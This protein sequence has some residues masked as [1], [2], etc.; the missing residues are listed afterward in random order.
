MSATNHTTNYE[1][2]I[3]IGTDK[4]AWLVDW[5]GAMN[6]IDTAIKQAETKADQAGTDVGSIQSDII[7]INSSLTTLNNAVSQ[8][9][10]DTNA[11]TGSIN[12][13]Q[14]L[15][16]NG[17]PTTTDKTI[18]GAINEINSKIYDMTLESVS[19][20]VVTAG[21]HL[22][23]QIDNIKALLNDDGT[24]GKIY[25]FV[26]CEVTEDFTTSSP[27]WYE[28]CHFTISGLKAGTDY[29]V[30]GFAGQY[31]GGSPTNFY[32]DQSRLHIVGTTVYIESC[33][34]V[35]TAGHSIAVNL[36]PC[37]IIFEDLGD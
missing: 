24:L 36:P 11:N 27:Y 4:P 5:N 18:I 14:E 3:F 2:P 26:Q 32:P 37:V 29:Y 17:T 21:A 15:I 16:G 6:A 7:T 9:R 13:I 34:Q 8:L 31:Y 22:S 25:G 30:D 19:G 28:V 35:K 33:R 23:V 20:I 10:L 12:T 1:F